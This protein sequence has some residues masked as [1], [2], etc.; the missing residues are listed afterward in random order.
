MRAW[1]LVAA[2]LLV[3]GVALAKKAP[4]LPVMKIEAANGA[5]DR[6]AVLATDAA[7]ESLRELG[8]F[9]VLSSEDIRRILDFERTKQLSGSQC[10]EDRC[11]AEI[12]GALG[13]DFMVSGKLT[14]ISGKLKLDLQLFNNAKAKVDESASQDGITD[15]K[16]L[17]DAA[18]SLARRVVARLLERNSGQ[19]FVSVTDPGAA[20]ATIEVDGK[21]IG[22]TV[23]PGTQAA[24]VVLGWGPHRA[25]IAKEGFLA[26]EKDVQIDEGQGTTL[27]VTLVPSPD[28][29]QSYRGRNQK[30]RI[31]AYASAGVA[32][33]LTGVAAYFNRQNILLYKRYENGRFE[34]E[35]RTGTRPY[36][37]VG[38]LD[39]LKGQFATQSDEDALRKAKAKGDSELK[40]IA[41]TAG[42]AGVAAVAAVVLYIL[43]DDPGRY[44][45]FEKPAG[46]EPKTEPTATP[47]ATSWVPAL[48]FD[49]TTAS[50]GMTLRF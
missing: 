6:Q 47:A 42:G 36:E 22:I 35:G 31:G 17:V 49:G 24:P 10:S 16:A 13:A 27:V 29:I 20:G 46:S 12:G 28:F 50:A 44:D 2:L 15:E 25:R 8:V 11:L 48:S 32:V 30:L 41:G 14:K 1:A 21:A 23:P 38:G 33:A 3:P 9:R 26:F 5:D 43:S 7:A 19:L 18:K 37:T 39:V 4:A 45:A 40:L 34:F